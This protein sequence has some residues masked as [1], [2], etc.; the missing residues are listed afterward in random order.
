MSERDG[1]DR[2]RGK[3]RRSE[4]R[5]APG[6]SRALC[7]DEIEGTPLE[8]VALPMPAESTAKICGLPASYANFYIA[9]K[10]VLL[11]TFNDPE[12]TRSPKTLAKL[13]PNRRI[14]PN[15]LPRTD[16]GPRRLSLP[17]AAA[18]AVAT[19]RL[20]GDLLR[21]RRGLVTALQNS[22]VQI[23]RVCSARVEC[24]RTRSLSVLTFTSCTP[25]MRMSGS[26]NL[27]T[28]SSQSSP[29]VAISIVSRIG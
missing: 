15:R 23:R 27:R 22:I 4:L 25:G 18:A 1:R 2:G 29:S 6:K 17:D 24:D 14:V 12:T 11:P 9:N 19:N 3:S 8:I 26:R 5:T 7:V 20:Q 10:C 21:K 16:L 28:H 13:F